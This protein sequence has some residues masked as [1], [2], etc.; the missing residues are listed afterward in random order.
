MLDQQQQPIYNELFEPVRGSDNMSDHIAVNGLNIH[1]AQKQL[2]TDANLN[3]FKGHRYALVGK[4]GIGK[5]TLLK[6][7]NGR[8]NE[9]CVIPKHFNILYVEQE[10]TASDESVIQSVINSDIL[11][12]ELLAAEDSM[13]YGDDSNKFDET[14]YNLIQSKL[15]EIGAYSAEARAAAILSG[16]QFSLPDQQKPVRE[17][18][19]GW[20]MRIALARALFLGPTLLF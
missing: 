16:L 19:G 12:T 7:I 14:R 3:L 20:R 4:N 15:N 9:F 5:S 10:V 8:V 1:L 11:R 17:F 2:F 6:Y 18:S 13:F